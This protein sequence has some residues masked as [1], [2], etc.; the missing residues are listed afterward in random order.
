VSAR[1]RRAGRTGSDCRRAIDHVTR[2][3]AH[4]NEHFELRIQLAVVDA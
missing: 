2:N 1:V 4:G 3:L